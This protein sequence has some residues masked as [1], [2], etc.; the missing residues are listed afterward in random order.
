MHA[1][2]D[3]GSIMGPETR[4]EASLY[5]YMAWPWTAAAGA[6]QSARARTRARERAPVAPMLW[7]A[8]PA[9]LY[10]LHVT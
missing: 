9:V 1:Y 5:T 10:V 2:T 8:S 3:A 4:R 7:K 6:S